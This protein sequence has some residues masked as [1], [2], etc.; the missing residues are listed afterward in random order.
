MT[1]R[2]QLCEID[3][4]MVAADG[5]DEAIIGWTDSWSGYARPVRIVYNASRIIELLEA[6]GLSH[7]EAREHFEF[8]I[9]G[10]Y[11]GER[12]PVF[13]WMVEEDRADG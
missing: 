2:E 6:A 4:D 13:V 11:V 1:R 8:N 12:T 10:A 5:W 9:S 7:E 3:P